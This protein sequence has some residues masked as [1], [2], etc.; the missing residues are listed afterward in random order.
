MEDNQHGWV[1]GEVAL[2]LL[3]W[4]DSRHSHTLHWEI[5]NI[6]C[7]YPLA[8]SKILTCTFRPDLLPGWE[9][10]S[11]KYMDK[12]NT[13]TCPY[14]EF[15]VIQ[16]LYKRCNCSYL[17]S[18]RESSEC[19]I[20][21]WNFQTE[22]GPFLP[23]L[24][25]NWGEALRPFLC[26]QQSSNKVLYFGCLGT[27]CREARQNISAFTQVGLPV[28]YARTYVGPTC[29]YHIISYMIRTWYR[30][31]TRHVRT[32]VPCGE[33]A[34][35]ALILNVVL[36]LETHYASTEAICLKWQRHCQQANQ[37]RRWP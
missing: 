20:R 18:I 1:G 3:D 37:Q 34:G 9:R 8:T 27:Y 5:W 36:Y 13:W 4:L 32:I 22:L 19:R 29:S 21:Y 33:R 30:Y 23:F 31:D 24:E 11:Y 6:K 35:R 17:T 16:E 7:L 12:P 10:R 28:H 26:F 15:C 14:G 2:Q 25:S